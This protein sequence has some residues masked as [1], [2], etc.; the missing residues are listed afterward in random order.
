M[1]GLLFIIDD[2]KLLPSIANENV[3]CHEMQ[4]PAADMHKCEVEMCLMMNGKFRSHFTRYIY[5]RKLSV[6][7]HSSK[8]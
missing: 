6:L 8:T 3:P 2:S 7:L 4:N 5:I 1:S